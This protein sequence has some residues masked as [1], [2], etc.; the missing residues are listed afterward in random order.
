ML[1]RR[2]FIESSAIATLGA[3]ASGDAA[4]QQR[5]GATIDFEFVGLCAF[6][7]DRLQYA[8]MRVGLVNAEYFQ[9]LLPEPEAHVPILAVR[10]DA[11]GPE[12]GGM[13]V[14]AA[15]LERW[16]KG[17]K[18]NYYMWPLE[19]CEVQLKVSRP[20]PLTGNLTKAAQ[21][22]EALKRAKNLQTVPAL[23]PE[24]WVS[25]KQ[26]VNA[27]VLISDGRRRNGNPRPDN[28]TYK[29]HRARWTYQPY[30]Q[31]PLTQ[32]LGDVFACTTDNVTSIER[33]GQTSGSIPLN[34]HATS[35]AFIVNLPACYSQSHNPRIIHH[36]R[37]Y[38]ALFKDYERDASLFELLQTPVPIATAL[39]QNRATPPTNESCLNEGDV[40][41]P[42]GAP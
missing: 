26:V 31:P 20:S 14:P 38:Y 34:D 2:E 6:V 32:E 41:C 23:K 18:G 13:P 16:R 9:N 33:S 35:H 4:A 40:Y 25:T 17:T 10:E 19:G 24:W 11:L 1:S 22:G 30:Q 29:F 37:S 21:L 8:G 3:L 42:G 36:V 39:E 15:Q 7:Q 27:S 28:Y 5:P 12:H